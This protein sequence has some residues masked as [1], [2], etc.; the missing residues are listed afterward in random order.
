M[1]EAKLGGLGFKRQ[2]VAEV[3]PEFLG[4]FENHKNKNFRTDKAKGSE[5]VKPSKPPVSFLIRVPEQGSK[6]SE[7][8]D[9]N[10]LNSNKPTARN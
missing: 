5:R 10:I 6:K 9:E 7:W 1:R 8:G 4:F 3:R 2:R